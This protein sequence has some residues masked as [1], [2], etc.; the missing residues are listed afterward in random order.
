MIANPGR[1]V[2]VNVGTP[3]LIEWFGR[4]AA[5]AIWKSPV[6]SC[7]ALRGVNLV[8]DDQGD[9]GVHGGPD[10]AVYA[11]ARE[12]VLWWEARLG[13]PVPPGAFGENL[14]LTGVAVTDALI[15]ERWQIGN[16][17]LEVSQPRFPCWKL[18]ARMNDP[19]FPR[20]FAEAGRLGAYLRIITEGDVGA[21]DTVLVVHRPPHVVT[22][23]TV[24]DI[25]LRDRARATLLLTVP[26]LAEGLQRWAREHA[27]PGGPGP[28]G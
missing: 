4:R 26:E 11:Y 27:P 15:G 14:T 12:D 6:E 5:T 7:V 17:L 2:S 16:A 22:I 3:R 28:R 20:R 19:D 13:R 23:G 10:K 9:R 18:G 8:G 24:G 25:Y 1:V 21:G